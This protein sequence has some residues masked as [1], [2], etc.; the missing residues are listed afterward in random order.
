[1]HE[2]IIVDLDP[3]VAVCVDLLERLRD[4]LD[5]HAC[6]HETVERDALR[7]LAGARAAFMN[8]LHLRSKPLNKY[9]ER[10]RRTVLALDKAEQLRREVIAEL[11]QRLLELR[12]VNRAGAVAVEVPEDVLPVFD[13]FPEPGELVEADS[14]AAVGVLCEGGAVKMREDVEMMNKNGQRW[15]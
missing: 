10:R 12:A 15:S 9:Q 2:L 14:A 1:M 8:V 7:P 5:D 6:A 11:R 13:V 3:A 4:L